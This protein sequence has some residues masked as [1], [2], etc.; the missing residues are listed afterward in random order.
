MITE[1]VLAAFWLLSNVNAG[2]NTPVGLYLAIGGIALLLMIAMAATKAL[3]NK[4][5]KN[6][7]NKSAKSKATEKDSETK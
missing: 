7:Q 4:E 3:S 2:D 5:N 1:I 6:D